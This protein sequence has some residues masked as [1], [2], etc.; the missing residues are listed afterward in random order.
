[1]EKLADIGDAV[2]ERLEAVDGLSNVQHSLEEILQE[3]SVSVDRERATDL[4]L[5]V[6]AVGRAL[7]V[8]L[9]GIVVTDFIEGDRKFDVRL[10]LPRGEISS[11]RDLESILLTEGGD[12]LRPVHLGDLATVK[13]VPSAMTIQRDRQQRIMEISAN[14]SQERSLAEIS[15]DIQQHLESLELPAGYTLYDGGTTKSLQEG[16]RTGRVLLALAV[17]L[18]LVVM[19]VQYESLRNPLVILFSVPF[20]A[21]GVAIGLESLD[22]AL[23]M[24]VWL[25]MI[26]LAGIVVN[27]AI[28]LVEY[29]EISRQDGLPSADAIEQA[30]RLRLRPILMTTLTTVAGMLPLAL[31]WGDGAEMLQPLATTIV[32]GLSFSLLVT[33]IL[34]PCVYALAQ[35]ARGTGATALRSTM[36]P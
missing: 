4:G 20:A 9:D 26:M 10:R 12:D 5:S 28:V 19:A 7:R 17:F 34:V 32:A 14:V 31:A 3:L 29:I 22:M 27:N 23:S 13:L 21:I 33:L 8:A 1:M 24:P 2:T 16:Q 25:G 35:G 18:V 30:G 15:R 36:S 6:E 11:P